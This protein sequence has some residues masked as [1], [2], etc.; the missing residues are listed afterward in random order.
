MTIVYIF[1]CWVGKTSYVL[2][3]S[4]I[5]RKSAALI[6]RCS[7]KEKW[8]S[9]VFYCSENPYNLWTTGRIQVGF[10]AKC[11][12]PNR[13]LQSNKKLKMS[14]VRVPTDFPRSHHMY[15]FG[16]WTCMQSK[17]SDKA[18]KNEFKTCSR[19]SNTFRGFFLLNLVL[20]LVWN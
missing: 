13:A 14:H 6:L 18:Y 7:Q 4:E 2:L 10:S 9:I 8:I 11:T 15:A 12:S 17:T 5:S 3:S 1:H 20:K 19:A 16:P